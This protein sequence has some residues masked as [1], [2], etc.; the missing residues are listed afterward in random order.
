MVELVEHDPEWGKLANEKIKQLWNIFG[1]AAIDIQHVGSTAILG[2]KTKPVIDIAVAVSNFDDVL[3]LYPKL[4]EQGVIYA[5]GA[6]DGGVLAFH[7]GEYV[8]GETFPRIMTHQIHVVIADSQQWHDR[9][10]YRDYMNSHPAAAREYERLKLLLAEANSNSY[11]NY[12][13]SKYDYVAKTIRVARQWNDSGR[14]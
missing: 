5:G 7:C 11:S 10:N 8:A 6:G 4:S 3:A 12:Y 1:D 14:I 9:I 2:I 13:F